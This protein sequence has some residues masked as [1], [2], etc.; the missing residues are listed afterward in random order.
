MQL[1]LFIT[2]PSIAPLFDPNVVAANFLNATQRFDATL[3][4]VEQLDRN[5]ITNTA[6]RTAVAPLAAPVVS[7]SGVSAFIPTVVSSPTTVNVSNIPPGFGAG[8]PTF[9]AGATTVGTG[10]GIPTF[11]PGATT[12]GLGVGIPTFAPGATTVGLGVGV[13]TFVAGNTT[14][15]AGAGAPTFNPATVTPSSAGFMTPT[16]SFLGTM[17]TDPVTSTLVPIL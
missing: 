3:P 2:L 1:N 16:P 4:A 7:P 14:V 17:F 9:A 11:V 13:P 10:A 15:G 6:L 5:V 8:T 12:V